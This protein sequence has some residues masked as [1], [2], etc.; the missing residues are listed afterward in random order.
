V[1]DLAPLALSHFGVEAPAS[2]R[3]RSSV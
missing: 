3:V 1:T 2:M